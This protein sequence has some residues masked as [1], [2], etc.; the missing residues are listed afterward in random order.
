M[1]N[2]FVND[3][4]LCCGRDL[5]FNPK[6]IFLIKQRIWTPFENLNESFMTRTSSLAEPAIS[7]FF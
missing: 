2:A 6:E 3:K 4:V 7:P 1:Q 5:F